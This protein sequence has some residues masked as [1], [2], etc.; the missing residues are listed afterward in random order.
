M[1]LLNATDLYNVSGGLIQPNSHDDTT[2]ITQSAPTENNYT[3]KSI[4]NYFIIGAGIGFPFTALTF[5]GNASAFAFIPVF[6]MIM[7]AYANMKVLDRIAS[8]YAP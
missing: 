6:G 4:I 8:T 1:Y 5:R 3:F 2:M 7:A